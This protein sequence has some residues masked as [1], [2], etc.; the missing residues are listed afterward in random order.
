MKVTSQFISPAV[1]RTAYSLRIA[2]ALAALALPISAAPNAQERAGA[3]L[4]AGASQS[5]AVQNT[6]G[7]RLAGHVPTAVVAHS[8]L[9]GRVVSTET[10]GLA[11]TLPLR[12]QAALSDLLT[13][14]YTPG[15]PLYGQYLTS[16]EF[17]ARFGPT[18]SDYAAVAA[19]AKR[20]GLQVTGTHPNRLILDVSGPANVVESAFSLHLQRYQNASGRVFR[21]PDANPALPTG[22]F[23]RLS[24]VIGLDN[25]VLL[26]PHLHPALGSRSGSG[27]GGGLT[28]ADI[29]T[30]Y[31]LQNTGA[32]GAGQTI[33]LFELDGYTPTDI[34]A[35]EAQFGLQAVPL[36][37]VLVDGAAATAGANADEVTLDIELAMA[38][39]PG[40]GKILI[41]E[42]P[43]VSDQNFL[44]GYNKIATDNIAKQVSTSWGAAED[45]SDQSLITAE[46]PIFQQM[47]AQG[48][49]IVAVTGD[50]GAYDDASTLSVDD[51]GAQPY[52]TGVGGTSLV[53]NGTG[54]AYA[55]ETVWSDPTPNSY[56]TYGSA[57]GGGFSTIWPAPGYQS[58]LQPVPAMRSV[59]DVALNSDPQ[60]GY[61]IYF[62]GQWTVYGGTSAA[63]PLWASFTALVNQERAAAGKG[64]IGFLNPP[65]YQIGASTVYDTDFHDITRGTNFYYPATVGYDNATGWGSFVGNALLST[66]VSGLAAAQTGTL[67]GTVTAADTG[68]AL[69]GVTVTALSASGGVSEGTT[70]TAADGSYTLAVPSG[71]ALTV[72]VSAYN[73]TGGAY[74]GAKAPAT[75]ALTA[76]QTAT[77]NVSLQPAHTY[78]AGLQMISSPYNYSAVGDFA[79]I[80]GLASSAVISSNRLIAWETS[81]NGYVFYPTAPANTLTPGSGYWVVFPG[82]AYPHFDGTLVS[83]AG[84]FSIALSAGWNLIGD[85]FP[86]AVP[87][88]SVTAGGTALASSSA[89]S[90]TLYSYNTAAGNYVTV[91]AASGSLQPYAGYWIFA[92]QSTTLNVPAP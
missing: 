78:A 90:P 40:L 35:Y 17:T 21:A 3:I 30:A 24:Q 70:T 33:A 9:L 19:A 54:G 58:V 7:P 52:V 72:T 2:A 85:P 28:P 18:E 79:A 92:G 11:L 38:L 65:I 48:Q 51:P 12:N 1:S 16:D 15:D 56:S 37:N 82:T 20:L 81:L 63:A 34:A 59:P 5:A 55:S 10:I 76:G 77:V 45:Q 36:Q 14:L 60:T 71:L 64:T 73:A 86:S 13:R 68:A 44:D 49:T 8:H 80:F 46:N 83:T 57:G 25:A 32:T 91:S 39:T 74:A 22:L 26:H 27:P 42:T 87:L 47:A 6:V 23:G 43:N 53:T 50:A 29:L 67:T 31:S 69:P 61:S 75:A 88:S 4:R 62:G 66:L 89:V 84:P 41:Y